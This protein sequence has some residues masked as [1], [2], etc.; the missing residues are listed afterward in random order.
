MI[1]PLCTKTK[2]AKRKLKKS[3]KMKK[4]KDLPQSRSSKRIP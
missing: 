3:K 4:K 1:L 2:K